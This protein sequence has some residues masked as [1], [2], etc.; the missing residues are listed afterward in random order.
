M[1]YLSRRVPEGIGKEIAQSLDDPV[2]IRQ[3]RR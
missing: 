3:H 2:D 1:P